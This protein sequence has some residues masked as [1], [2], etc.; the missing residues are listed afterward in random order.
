M[1][2]VKVST[3]RLTGLYLTIEFVRTLALIRRRV[4][5]EYRKSFGH[6]KKAT[7]SSGNLHV[8]VDC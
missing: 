5:A 6:G 1:C 4:T 2:K 8:A 7:W 3:T